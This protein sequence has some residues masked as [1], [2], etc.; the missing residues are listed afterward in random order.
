MTI[1]IVKP[2]RIAGFQ[3]Y[4]FK[5]HLFNS[6]FVRFDQLAM[7]AEKWFLNFKLFDTAQR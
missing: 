6:K 3:R 2:Q 7:V 4:K 5:I 1:V